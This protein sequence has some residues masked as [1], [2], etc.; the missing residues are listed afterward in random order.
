MNEKIIHQFI[1]LIHQIKNDIDTS[2]GKEQIKH[3]YRLS[4]INKILII[5]KEFPEKIKSS[6]QLKNI[7]GIGKNSLKRI[8]EI[9]KTGKLKEIKKTKINNTTSYFKS[10]DDLTSIFGIGEIKAKE[11]VN[12]YKI[13]NVDDLKKL[14]IQKKIELPK[15]IIKGIKYSNKIKKNIPRNEIDKIYL[16]LL[17]TVINFDINLNLTICGS[18]RRLKKTSNDIDILLYH[19]NIITKKQNNNTNIMKKF[20]EKLIKDKFII[21]NFTSLD[22]PTKFMGICKFKNNPIRRI[23]IRLIPYESIHTAML[24]FTGSRD[25][26]KKMRL[27]A[28]KKNYILNEYGIYHKKTNKKIKVNSENDVFK[29]LDMEYLTPDLRK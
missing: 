17:T 6:D 21:D 15:N 14:I 18:Y 16:Y 19:N 12:K 3:T 7:K 20:I 24:Y 29:L 28:I 8:D 10:I 4:S 2:T 26:N 9:I 22:V 25:F 1:L 13:K 23:D 11:L 27:V 5:L